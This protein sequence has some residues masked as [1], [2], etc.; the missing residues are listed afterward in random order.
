MTET[1]I[2]EEAVEEEKTG[3]AK[4][5]SRLR[6][7]WLHRKSA[8]DA[9]ESPVTEQENLTGSDP[10]PLAYRTFSPKVAPGLTAA[11]G[12]LAILGGL[13]QWVRATRVV[14][15]GLQPELVDFSMGYD[16]AEGV[17]M[18]VFGGIAMLTSFFWLRRRPVFKVVPSIAIK[19]IPV[20]V[21]LAIVGL[22]VWEL[23][24][25]DRSAQGLAQQ[26]IDRADFV[27]FHAGLGWGAWCLIVAAVLLFLGTFVGILR[28]F[29]LKRGTAA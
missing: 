25:I 15:E 11:G 14:T 29:D 3:V 17:T 5:K 16:D 9:E 12:A 4:A 19:L 21:S 22:A 23:P 13:G 7:P 20:L 28:E 18:A 27:S 24:L 8:A 26:A 6:L 10:A 2:L 1:A